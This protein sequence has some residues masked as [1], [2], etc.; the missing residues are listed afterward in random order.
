MSTVSGL[1]N[2]RDIMIYIKGKIE[3]VDEGTRQRYVCTVKTAGMQVMKSSTRSRGEALTEALKYLGMP[4]YTPSQEISRL[5]K[6][7]DRLVK[8]VEDDIESYEE[9]CGECGKPKVDT[10][11]NVCLNVCHIGCG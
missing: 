9:N 4:M 7:G 10:I 3:T 6:L 8:D 1:L 5:S 2:H 11:S